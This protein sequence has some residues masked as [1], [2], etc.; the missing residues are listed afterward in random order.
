MASKPGKSLEAGYSHDRRDLTATPL[1]GA[2]RNKGTNPLLIKPMLGSVKASTYD[3]PPDF[4]HEYGLKQMRDGLTS[5]MVVGSWAQ[6][7]GTQGMMP[8]RDFKGLNKAAVIGG[9]IDTKSMAEYRKTHDI[10]LKLGSEK[11]AEKKPFDENSAFGRPTRPSTPFGDLVSHGFRYDWVMSS[12]PAESAVQRMKPKKPTMT[13]ASM[14]HAAAA[15]SKIE[16]FEAGPQ[17]S[18]WKMNKFSGVQSKIG[19]QG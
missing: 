17:E 10:R 18:Q 8:A 6:H 15:A 13:R 19:K 16:G 3:L 12:E 4:E 5:E 7:D 2:H 11:S 1:C 9:C 14:G